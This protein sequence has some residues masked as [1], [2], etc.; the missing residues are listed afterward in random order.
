MKLR[1][2]K[3]FKINDTKEGQT[4]FMMADISALKEHIGVDTKLVEI[5]SFYAE[6]EE[7]KTKIF[8][9]LIDEYKDCV[10]LTCDCISTL[11]FPDKEY[12]DPFS[13]DKTPDKKDIDVDFIKER[14]KKLLEGL[15]FVDINFYINYE[16][17]TAYMYANEAAKPFL[18]YLYGKR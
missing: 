7:E 14:D 18:E 11:E 4:S 10:I 16:F 5:C 17:K 9:E 6:T 3:N 12:N 1:D 13:E 2:Y 8:Y 15:G